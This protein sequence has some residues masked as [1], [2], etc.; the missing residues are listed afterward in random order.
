MA[1]D[2]V[3][4]TIPRSTAYLSLIRRLVADV[5]RGAGFNEVE[6]GEIEVAVDEVA[7]RA[8]QHRFDEDEFASHDR[9]HVAARVLPQ[10][11]EIL[12][13][14]HGE[15]RKKTD[16]ADDI[17]WEDY[18]REYDLGG[19]DEFVVKTFMDEVEFTHRSKVGN[20]LRLVRAL[21]AARRPPAA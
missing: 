8:V 15:R 17:D 6:V 12:I 16:S 21:P 9:I 20:E 2:E 7:T 13:R 19:F 1:E 18:E 5:A 11:L 3:T 10:T 14:D 4:L